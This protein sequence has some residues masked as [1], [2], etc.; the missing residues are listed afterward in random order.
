MKSLT[1]G[2]KTADQVQSTL[3][4]GNHRIETQQEAADRD[5]KQNLV[6]VSKA[7]VNHMFENLMLMYPYWASTV[8]TDEDLKALKRAWLRAFL[9]NGISSYEQVELGL[10]RAYT[11]PS[12]FIPS[13]TKFVSWCKPEPADP[14]KMGLPHPLTAFRMACAYAHSVR[15]GLDVNNTIEIVRVAAKNV[16]Y[17]SLEDAGEAIRSRFEYEYSL[18][19][20]RLKN[21]LNLSDHVPP[22]L[23]TPQTA[24]YARSESSDSAKEKAMAALKN[25]CF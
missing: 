18:L 25:M 6:E 5:Q 19:L 3:F 9:L 2:A 17:A 21:G 14:L 7:I 11:E 22:P 13:V 12:D 10:K 23:P 4:S 16:G 1:L 15:Y 8:K 24:S 20:E